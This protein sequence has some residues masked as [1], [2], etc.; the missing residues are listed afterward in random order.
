MPTALQAGARECVPDFHHAR[1]FVNEPT[2]SE[3][4][5]HKDK[6][7]PGH[8]QGCRKL[9]GCKGKTGVAGQTSRTTMRPSV[10]LACGSISLNTA[11]CSSL[12]RESTPPCANPP[13]GLILS[14]ALK[15]G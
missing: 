1:N 2:T 14:F 15:R 10:L 11:I 6:S 3:P 8:R 9:L 12:Y 4:G 7:I 13:P 5:N